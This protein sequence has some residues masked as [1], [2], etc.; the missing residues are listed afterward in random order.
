[1]ETF[2]AKLALGE[3]KPVDSPHKDQGGGPLMF[4]LI[5]VWTNGRANNRDTGDLRRHGA[6]YDVIF[7]YFRIPSQ[8][9]WSS[10]RPGKSWHREQ[11]YMSQTTRVNTCWCNSKLPMPSP[12]V[13]YLGQCEQDGSSVVV[14]PSTAPRSARVWRLVNSLWTAEWNGDLEL[15]QQWLREWLLLVNQCWLI[16]LDGIHIARELLVNLIDYNTLKIITK[17]P[18]GQCVNTRSEVWFGDTAYSSINVHIHFTFH[19]SSRIY[20]Q[21]TQYTQLW[22]I[23]FNFNREQVCACLCVFVI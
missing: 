21:P 7:K 20:L 4:S 13:W 16:V 17:S 12:V 5:C 14:Q 10:C 9:F 6:H 23:R 18:R 1:M 3:G 8:E 11:R 15:G 2:S 19:T 22:E